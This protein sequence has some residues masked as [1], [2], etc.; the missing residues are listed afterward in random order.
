MIN[1]N[2]VEEINKWLTTHNI[3]LNAK[4]I[5]YAPTVNENG[6]YFKDYLFGYDDNNELNEFLEKNNIFLIYKP[7]PLERFAGKF[8]TKNVIEYD[9]PTMISLY[10]L[11]F[12]SDA[13]ITNFSSVAMDY[14]ITGKP[15]IYNFVNINDYSEYRGLD[16]D[17]PFALCSDDYVDSWEG[18]KFKLLNLDAAPSKRYLNVQKI[19]NTYIDGDS[20]LRICSILFE[21]KGSLYQVKEWDP[22]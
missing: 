12:K 19:F 20:K 10:D 2:K 18:L 9:Y 3:P 6:K 16:F 7:H 21:Q 4:L 1:N 22:K 5:V 15:V 14:L 13:L 8:T 17:P 11:L